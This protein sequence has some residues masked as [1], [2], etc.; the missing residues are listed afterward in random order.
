MEILNSTQKYA[1]AENVEIQLLSHKDVLTIMI[2]DDGIG[3]RENKSEKIAY[4]IGIKSI[5]FRIGYL[6]GHLQTD[7]N[8]REPH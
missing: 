6:N 8:D 3:Y 5:N 4:G 7:R 2:E 1:K